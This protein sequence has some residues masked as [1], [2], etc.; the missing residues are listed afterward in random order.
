MANKLYVGAHASISGGY[1]IGVK[2]ILSIGGNSVQ[3]FLKNPRRR[4]T[5]NLKEEDIKITK[6]IVRK[7]DVFLVGHCSYLLNFAKPYKENPWAVDSLTEDLNIISK[8]EGKG[9]V[10][11]IGKRLN[12]SDEEAFNN[13]VE[14]INLVLERT[15]KNT[16]VIWENTAGQGT[17]IGSNFEELKELYDKLKDK[18]RIRFCLD[19]CHS[20]A[21]GYDLSNKKGIKKWKEEFDKLIGW[22]KVICVH[23]NDSKKGLG[24]RVDRHAS[25][26]E[27]KIGK[28]GLK[29]VAKLCY[30]DSIP[31]ILETPQNYEGYEKEIRL[32]KSWVGL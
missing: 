6:E 20:F 23:F 24:S 21:A 28:E 13:I 15:P 27:G 16:F 19:T 9:V 5:K 11:H 14:N 25:L 22:E 29:E 2:D 3:I 30:K 10:L 8:I 7:E 4:L 31:M 26:L 1:N 18:S 12:Y 17:E 32:I